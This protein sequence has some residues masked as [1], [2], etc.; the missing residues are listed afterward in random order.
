VKA[1]TGGID[2]LFDVSPAVGGPVIRDKLWYYGDYRYSDKVNLAP[3]AYYAKDPRAVVYQPDLNRPAQDVFTIHWVDTRFTWQATPKNKFAVFWDDQ[4]V[5]RCTQGVS[6]TTTPEASFLFHFKPDWL[7]QLT[8]N[9]PV[10]S[11][12]L[13]E[14][15]V[16]V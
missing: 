10:T 14:A 8:W 15:T 13:I 1:G 16:N 2:T 7:T 9:S 11:K 3:G 4:W 12:F 5:C 6:A